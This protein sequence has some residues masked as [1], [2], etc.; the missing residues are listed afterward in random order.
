M[1]SARRG[2]V[3][4]SPDR[5][6]T[7]RLPL[8]VHWSPSD[9][10]SWAR[11]S[12]QLS[13]AGS[14]SMAQDL[15]VPYQFPLPETIPRRR[16]PLL[17]ATACAMRSAERATRLARVR[18]LGGDDPTEIGAFRGRRPSLPDRP[19]AGS[20]VQRAA[21]SSGTMR[22]STGSRTRPGAVGLA[23]STAARPAGIM[24][25]SASSRAT[26]SLFERAQ[27]LP[28]RRGEYQS[29]PRSSSRLR[30]VLS[31]QP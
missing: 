2:L 6:A 31:I 14:L 7:A 16:V 1:T 15:T 20:S 27:T 3:N 29:M 22:S 30:Y 8:L 25:P 23:C 19:G 10:P 12:G 24:R 5:G 9:R 11:T 18:A 17:E 26:R 28:L 21:R 4:A 13:R